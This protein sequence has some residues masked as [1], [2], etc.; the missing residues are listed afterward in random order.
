MRYEW[1]E[2]KR[3]ANLKSHGLDSVDAPEVF[4]RPT[5]T[6]EDDR[7]VGVFDCHTRHIIWTSYYT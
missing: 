2:V 5:F 6:F 7:F 4:G 3:E 1:D